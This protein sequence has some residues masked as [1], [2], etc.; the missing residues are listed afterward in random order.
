MFVMGHTQ[1]RAASTVSTVSTAEHLMLATGGI[2]G[3]PLIATRSLR[4][5]EK[6]K[7]DAQPGPNQPTVLS[8]TMLAGHIRLAWERNKMAREKITQRLLKCLR[9]RRGVY[10]FDELQQIADRGGMNVVWVDLTE[11]KC[12]AGGAWVREVVMPVNDYPFSV[13]PSPMPDLP[14]EAAQAIL[15]K[16]ANEARETMVRIA[17][18]QQPQQ[19]AG[20]PGAGGPPA[21]MQPPAG[22]MDID[23]FRKMAAEIQASMQDEVE[24]Q[25]KDKAQEAADGMREKIQDLMAEGGWQDAID[26]FIED[27]VTYPAA[28]LMGP[29]YQRCAQLK[30]GKGWIPEVDMSPRMQWKWIDIFDCYPAQYAT[31]CQVGD[32]C[33]RIRYTRKE[34]SDCRGLEDYRDDQITKALLAYTNGHLEGWIWQEAER[35]RLQQESL[36]SWLSPRGV[37]DAVHYWGSVPG[38]KLQSWGVRDMASIDP[39]EEYEVDA[40]LIGP[41]VIRCAV[42]RDPLK[43][44]PFFN[45]SFDKIPGS[46]WGRSIPDLCDTAQKMV[47]AS[48][49]SLADNMGWA[50]GPQAWVHV[51]RLADGENS[52]EIIPMK[53]WQLKSDPTQGVNP[54]VGFFQA[55]SNSVE[56]QTIIEKWSVKADDSTGV[57]RYTY[58]NER[59]GGAADTYSGLAMLMNNAA[60]GLRRAI[61]QIDLNVIE[62]SVY[63]AFVNE[64][65]HGTDKSIKGDCVIVPKGATAMLV[66]EAR[67]QSLMTGAQ[68]TANPI[69]APILGAKGR[70]AI[71]RKV[72]Q[73]A[74]EINP[75]GIIPTDEQI[76]Q[77]QQQ[78]AQQQQAMMQSQ[79]EAEQQAEQAKQQGQMAIA[80][81]NNESREKIAGAQLAAQAISKQQPASSNPRAGIPN[82]VEPQAAQKAPREATM[83]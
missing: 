53:I 67:N 38:W 44:R 54:G 17:Q 49:C 56:L 35:Q 52:M 12:K 3:R 22:I 13:S 74:L 10:S 14:Q 29:V 23:S 19:P 9:A 68:L 34:L 48:A 11:E 63:S 30:W 72:F 57:P 20:P 24:Q 15:E 76:E 8:D 31:S 59:V 80:N 64:M 62:P 33:I 47:N 69:D 41:Y 79:V 75:E 18:S 21:A 7:E 25:Y 77:Q 50:A 55:A 61:A 26:G 16:A 45:A 1:A 2:P 66:K 65:V 73:D 60:K 78:A 36:Y 32:L 82:S 58:G 39:V 46:F 40:I 70:A 42:N 5:I 83:A 4:T 51:D 81:S 37:I 71:L 43:R 27:F 6:A 28:V